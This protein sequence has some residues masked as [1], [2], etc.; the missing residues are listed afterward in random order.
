MKKIKLYRFRALGDAL[1]K[2]QPCQIF[3]I[4]GFGAL[5]TLGNLRFQNWLTLMASVLPLASSFSIAGI[6][7]IG[8]SGKRFWRE[9]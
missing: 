7:S 2:C 3:V 4:F 1:F 8:M 6:G 5:A 9:I